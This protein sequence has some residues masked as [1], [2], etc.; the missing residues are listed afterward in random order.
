MIMLQTA[1]LL[2]L[3]VTIRAACERKAVEKVIQ[4]LC[5]LAMQELLVERLLHD[6]GWPP[7]HRHV[8]HSEVLS[9][10]VDPDREEARMIPIA[11]ARGRV[12]FLKAFLE[13]LR[14]LVGVPVARV[15]QS[16]QRRL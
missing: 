8:R 1:W 5:V 10:R 3:R 13:R 14:G 16:G 6:G 7:A 15:N 11:D 12:P 9:F 2:A 4:L